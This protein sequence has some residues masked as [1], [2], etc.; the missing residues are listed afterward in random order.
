VPVLKGV[1]GRACST[2]CGGFL[3][4]INATSIGKEFLDEALYGI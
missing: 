2:F 4:L 1:L 3:F